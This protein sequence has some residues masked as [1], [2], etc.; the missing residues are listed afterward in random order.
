MDTD[1]F[2]ATAVVNF[3]SDNFKSNGGIDYCN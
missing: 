1:N 2:D 3:G